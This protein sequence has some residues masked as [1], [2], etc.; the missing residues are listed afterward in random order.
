MANLSYTRTP[1]LADLL[2]AADPQGVMYIRVLNDNT[3][4][5]G[6]DPL[7]PTKIIDLSGESVAPY[8]ACVTAEGRLD[9]ALPRA[10]IRP[11]RRSGDYWFEIGGKRVQCGSLKELLAEALR[12][13]ERTQP[14]TLTILAKIRGRSRR[15]VARDPHKLFTKPHLVHDYA[16]TLDGG[17]YYG[18]NNSA[19]ET[20]IWLQRAA[21]CAGLEWGTEFRTSL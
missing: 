18:T 20:N 8:A 19:R 21:E 17:W 16:E 5:L 7:K 10:D 15:I 14:G 11:G 12:T 1:K 9:E 3:L 13:L 2:K 6:A 4:A